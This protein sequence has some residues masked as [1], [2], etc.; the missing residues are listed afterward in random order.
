[1]N[2]ILTIPLLGFLLFLG[3]CSRIPVTDGEVLVRQL[4][5]DF[6]S[7]DEEALEQWMSPGFQSAHQDGARNRSEELELLLG[8]QL[9]DYKLGHFYSTQT[10]NVLVVSYTVTVQE[11]IDGKKLP[12]NRSQRLSVFM[13]NGKS[14]KWIAH[15]NLNP[16]SN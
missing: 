6:A 1:M 14:W 12:E 9:G 4:W 13:H 2:K 10:A 11:T 7:C 16:M 3:A 15:A 5:T 8:L